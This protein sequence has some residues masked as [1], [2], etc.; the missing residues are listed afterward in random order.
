MNE[1]NLR[2]VLAQAT[3][4]EAVEIFQQTLRQCVRRAFYDAMEEEVNLLC[5]AKYKPSESEYKRAGSEHGSA[6]L[7]G[8]KEAV[9]RPR[10]R[11]AEG[12]V[13]LEVYK[14]ASSQR[15]IFKEVV[16]YLGQGLSQR[17]AAR[18]NPKSLS[19]SAASRMWYEKSLE[20]L[21]ELRTRKLTDYDL[22]CLMIDGIRIAEG[23]WLIVAM[24]IDLAGNKIMLDFEEGSSENATLVGELISR[25]K[26]RGVDSPKDRPF[27]VV[28]DGSCSIK[29]AVKKHW[30]DA[31]QQE[32]LVHM[33]RHTRDKLRT[34]DKADFDICCNRLREA[35]GLEAG[36][37]AFADLLDFL[38][39]RNAAAAL[40]L[41]ER[42][43]DLTAFYRLNLPST[44]NITFL[45]T[46]CIE[47]SFRNWREATG[48]VK[49]WSLKRDMVSRWG[50]SGM[51]WAESGFNKIR[52]ATDLG[53]LAAALS[54]SVTSSSL[55]LEDS[56]PADNAEDKP[57]TTTTR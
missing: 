35:Q 51:L 11:T 47:N 28:R 34:R 17:G 46:N 6:Y 44:L 45:N 43:E 31:I 56:T 42:R 49:R 39:E 33:Q 20:Q 4:S 27:L 18:V 10:V 41:R 5:G 48:N 53:A 32:C 40:A 26:E 22:V 15:N 12:E 9:I 25:L 29:K 24:G 38:S 57:C 30:P 13:T 14:A 1:I 19:K 21:N 7:E 36:A 52:H 8:E 54:A 3:E 2:N 23:I 50:A 55:R 16:S 37:E